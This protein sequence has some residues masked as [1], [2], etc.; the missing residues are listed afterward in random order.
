MYT[1][2]GMSLL[3]LWLLLSRAANPSLF[4]VLIRQ[5]GGRCCDKVEG[6]C[7][8]ADFED[9]SGCKSSEIG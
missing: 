1:L 6:G 4:T 2:Y 3:T 5:K 9:C 8:L 7:N